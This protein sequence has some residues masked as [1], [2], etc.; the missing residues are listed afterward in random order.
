MPDCACRVV[1]DVDPKR[2]AQVDLT[3]LQERGV[4]GWAAYPV[5]VAWALRQ[6]GFDQVQGFD[7]AFTSCVPVGSGLSS[8][9]AMTCSTALALDDVFGLGYGS[10]DAGRVTL[11]AAAMKSENDMAGA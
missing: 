4:A 1:S 7:A 5:G 8:S 2:V 11:I 10:S 9:A 6:A 3:D